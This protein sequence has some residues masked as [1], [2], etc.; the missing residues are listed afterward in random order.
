MSKHIGRIVRKKGP[1]PLHFV[2]KLKKQLAVLVIP[3]EE[4]GVKEIPLREKSR[5]FARIAGLGRAADPVRAVDVYGQILVDRHILVG[6]IVVIL[7]VGVI[8]FHR[9]GVQRYFYDALI[10]LDLGVAVGSG[11]VKGCGHRLGE[12][13][14]E[15]Q[16]LPALT[17][18]VVVVVGL[19]AV[20]VE[21]G[22]A[23]PVVDRQGQKT[24][25]SRQVRRVVLRH[26][27]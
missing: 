19:R 16:L 24:D 17:V 9:L 5:V 3:L 22:G 1:V 18:V 23:E 2:R 15:E 13:K 27:L 14:E 10:A 11:S 12:L 7:I 4:G 20:D 8:V 26:L 6:E 25:E 21:A